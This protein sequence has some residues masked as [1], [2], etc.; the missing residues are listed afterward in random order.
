M[1]CS[2]SKILNPKTKRCVSK[3]GVIG[4]M[5]AAK[6]NNTTNNAKKINA[7]NNA[8]TSSQ[9]MEDIAKRTAKLDAAHPNETTVKRA[10]TRVLHDLSRLRKSSAAAKVSAVLIRIAAMLGSATYRVVLLH[11][12]YVSTVLSFSSFIALIYSLATQDYTAQI[13]SMISI[14]VGTKM[15]KYSSKEIVR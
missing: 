5:M 3:T 2:S 9:V 15:M 4:K 12:L 11:S 8:K 13:V 1:T 6:N 7:K 14:M 10:V